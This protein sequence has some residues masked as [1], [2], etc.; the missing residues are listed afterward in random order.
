MIL[1]IQQVKN[2][3]KKFWEKAIH[4]GNVKFLFVVLIAL[5]CAFLL[6]TV[7]LSNSRVVG[8]S[9]YPVLN[10]NDWII[11]NRLEYVNSEPSF[12]D[13]IVFKKKDVTSD[14]IVK[15]VIGIPFD[16]VE[17]IDGY[18]YINNKRIDNDFAAMDKSE[19]MQKITVPKDSYFVM[20]DNRDLSVDSRKW[21]KPFVKKEQIIGK[22]KLKYFP[23]FKKFN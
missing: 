12:G 13:I 7:V 21:E 3:A 23:K 4:K 19:N 18:L 16:T 5:L 11:A 2:K 1:L 17:I 8:L 6:N 15:R 14:P 20:G 10:E 22:V 9:M